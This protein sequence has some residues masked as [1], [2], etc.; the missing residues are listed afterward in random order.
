MTLRIEL[1][2]DKE[3]ALQAEAVRRGVPAEV[4]AKTLLEESLPIGANGTASHELRVE[5]EER[6]LDA[7]AARNGRLPLLPPEAN[8][9][10]WIY[11]DHD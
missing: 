4:L 2:P 6:L 7:L 3:K 11:R 10:E 8:R 5:E 9:R 1:S